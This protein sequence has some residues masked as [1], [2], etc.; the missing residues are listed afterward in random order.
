MAKSSLDKII[1]R[2]TERFTPVIRNA[3]LAA[4]QDIS[5]NVILMDLIKALEANDVQ[6][7]FR[8]L[9]LSEAALRPLTAALAT[10]FEQGGV[11]VA[12]TFPAIL[13]TPDFGRTRFLFDV[14]NTRAE[15]WLK[16]QSS[17]LI[18][19]IQEDARINVMNALT[20]GMEKGAN[21]R[22]TALDI[23][24]YVN[25]VTGKREGGLIGL[26]SQQE[27]WVRNARLDLENLDERYFSRER[28]DKRF[29][30][31]V[32]KAMQ[33]GK[34][35]D[36]ATIDKLITRYKDKLLQLRGETIGRTE[37]IQAL[38]RSNFEAHMQAK[39]MG[40]M[41]GAMKEWDSAGDSRVRDSHRHM[42]G[43]KVGIDAPFVTPE[44]YQMMFPGDVSLGA[45]A[46]EVINCR[47]RSKLVID[48]LSDLD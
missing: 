10:T 22:A 5:D 1:E 31:V 46:K 48:W 4:I 38:N 45:P 42:D 25:K 24:G 33:D 28:R 36:K 11:A 34:P 47:C 9:G 23:V 41:R 13:N 3:F 37:S 19:E 44:G 12:T 2:L 39:D 17:R 21:P 30:S 14:R 35:L 43:Q 32:R 29:D 15:R 26:T 16:E 18:V 40:A 6:R 7:A 20:S 27:S 8:V